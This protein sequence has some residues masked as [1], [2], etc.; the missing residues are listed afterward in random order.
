MP[1]NVV[2]V[3]ESIQQSPKRSAFKHA[4]A[5]GL[6]ERSMRRMLHKEVH[7]HPYKT[8]VTQKLT[9]L[10]YETSWALCDQMTFPVFISSV[11]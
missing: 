8:M 3:R 4:A 2:R 11:W 7:L 9:E 1:E 10:E 6:F 5:L